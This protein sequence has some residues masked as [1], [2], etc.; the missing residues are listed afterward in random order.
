MQLAAPHILS[1]HAYSSEIEIS[2][3]YSICD[4][5]RRRAVCRNHRYRLD[6]LKT[7]LNFQC[8]LYCLLYF[9]RI[10]PSH[11]QVFTSIR[12]C[13]EEIAEYARNRQC[14]A[15]LGQDTDYI[16]YE[17]AQYYLSILKLNLLTMTTLNYNRWGLARHLAI[18]PDQLPVL[19]SLIGNDIVP[20]NDLKVQYS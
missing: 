17:G 10:I 1:C 4:C 20:A 7:F 16:I 8:E 19:A 15:I 5:I 13:D 2:Y 6:F 3:C 12:E 9:S 18:H 11:F 14:F